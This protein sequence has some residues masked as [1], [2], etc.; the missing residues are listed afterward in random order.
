MACLSACCHANPTQTKALLSRLCCTLHTCSRDL[1]T[2]GRK[3]T[4]RGSGGRGVGV[5]THLASRCCADLLPGLVCL[6]LYVA[7]LSRASVGGKHVR[8]GCSNRV[9]HST[10]H[11]A[12]I[13]QQQYP[14]RPVQT[15]QSQCCTSASL[16]GC[17]W[18]WC[19]A[20]GYRAARAYIDDRGLPAVRSVYASV[21]DK[22]GTYLAT[23]NVR[24]H[25]TGWQ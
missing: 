22:V 15:R 25:T 17:S 6:L 10:G 23:V 14:H 24:V 12:Q 20:F 3:L 21:Q 4:D 18:Q 2:D 16:L 19:V 11:G 5:P 8:L 1:H 13:T 7:A 9:A